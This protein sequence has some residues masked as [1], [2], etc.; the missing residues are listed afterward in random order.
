MVYKQVVLHFA[1]IDI[2]YNPWYFMSAS[3][4]I[5]AEWVWHVNT[6]YRPTAMIVWAFCLNSN[7]Q[8]PSCLLQN[9]GQL[10][11][12]VW[13]VRSLL[14]QC[15]Y[16]FSSAVH[17]TWTSSLLGP[18]CHPVVQVRFLTVSLILSSMSLRTFHFHDVSIQLILVIWHDMRSWSLL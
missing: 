1:S 14:S 7:F 3:E 13:H 4:S 15:V 5:W 8:T 2:N 6:K 17:M 18:R 16:D 12:S 10:G 9:T 11:V